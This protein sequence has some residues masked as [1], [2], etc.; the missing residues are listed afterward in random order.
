MKAVCWHGVED[1]RVDKVPDPEIINPRDAI[2][3]ITSTAICG[4][5]LHLYDGKVP[6]MM[7]GDNPRPRVHG[8]RRGG[9]PA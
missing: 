5:D 9:G 7:K 8:R 1:V 4:S 2:V 3:R 6:S